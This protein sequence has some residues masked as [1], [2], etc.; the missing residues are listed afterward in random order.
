M[1]A[2]AVLWIFAGIRG[3]FPFKLVSLYSA[4]FIL[5]SASQWLVA[6]YN[7]DYSVQILLQS[8]TTLYLFKVAIK[9]PRREYRKRFC[10]LMILA[11]MSYAY[12][13]IS[14]ITL[15]GTPY[16]IS[17]E[18]YNVITFGLSIAVI[19]VLLGVINGSSRGDTVLLGL[20]AYFANGLQYFQYDKDALPPH[21]WQKDKFIN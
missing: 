2:L 10:A 16:L 21:V 12:M 14:Y 4:F 20:L 11:V 5:C 17:I 6:N 1:T 3:P 19:W 9:A 18:V 13:F 8:L 7:L 15:T